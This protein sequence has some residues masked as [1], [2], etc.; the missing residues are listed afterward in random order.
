MPCGMAAILKNKKEQTI[1][2][3]TWGFKIAI[4]GEVNPS[5]QYTLKPGIH[6]V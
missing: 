3:S 6:L 1:S 4:D 2:L 5:G